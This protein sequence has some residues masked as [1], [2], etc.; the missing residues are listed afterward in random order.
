MKNTTNLHWVRFLTILLVA[1]TTVLA[2]CSGGGGGGESAP[3][4]VQTGTV[5]VF[6]KDG[7]RTSSNISG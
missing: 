1:V 5:A 7:P 2:G 3:A 6:V 4:S